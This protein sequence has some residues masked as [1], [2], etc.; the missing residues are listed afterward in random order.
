MNNGELKERLEAVERLTRLYRPE[1]T[2]H[3][4]VTSTS[5]VILLGAAGMMLYRGKAGPTELGLM[6]GS[7]GMVTYTAGQLL[8]MWDRA[9]SIIAPGAGGSKK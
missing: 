2:V 7:S 1:R 9:V 8:R 3:L 5:L 6:F 4:V